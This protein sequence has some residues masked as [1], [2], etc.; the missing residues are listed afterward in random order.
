MLPKIEYIKETMK[1]W[2]SFELTDEQ[3][4]VYLKENQIESFD[5]D[6]R[7]DFAEYLAKKITGMSYP[8]N[9]DS[10][11]YS[12]RFFEKLMVNAKEKGFKF[13]IK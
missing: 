1:K 8:M 11:E 12:Q 7:E 13:S 5:T 3:I 10:E 2:F 9:G 4:K 6:E